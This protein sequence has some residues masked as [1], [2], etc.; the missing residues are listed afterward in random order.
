MQCKGPAICSRYLTAPGIAI[1]LVLLEVR[2]ILEENIL[3]ENLGIVGTLQKKTAKV[4]LRI[5]LLPGVS[6]CLL[7]LPLVL[8]IC[9][10]N[11]TVWEILVS[12]HRT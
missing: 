3:L 6:F 5:E 8:F 12:L 7:G 10:Q 11:R 4:Q 1:L 2:K 9:N